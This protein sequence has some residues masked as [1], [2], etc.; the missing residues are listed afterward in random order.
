M[1]E[2]RS[3]VIMERRT[4]TTGEEWFMSAHDAMGKKVVNPEGDDLGEIADMRLAFPTGQVKYMVLKH[5]GVL[6]VGGKRFAVPPEAL[7]YHPGDKVFVV[8]IDKH[9]L[10]ESS[11]FDEGNWPR[12]ADWNLIRTGRPTTEPPS[13]EEAEA[14]ARSKTPPPEVVTTERVETRERPR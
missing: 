3:E 14:I 11:G 13:K 10:D 4:R 7:A 8:N 1:P 2:G 6:G 9:R 5:G 12:E